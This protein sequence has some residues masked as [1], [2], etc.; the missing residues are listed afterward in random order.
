MDNET[1]TA[2]L[3]RTLIEQSKDAASAARAASVA[4]TRGADRVLLLEQRIES[5]RAA[6]IAEHNK[7]RAEFRAELTALETEIEAVR[8]RVDGSK[9][10]PAGTPPVAVEAAAAS[11]RATGATHEMAALEGRVIAALAGAEAR[12]AADRAALQKQLAAQDR[13]LGV[14]GRGLRR[15][16]S[17]PTLRT[18]PAIIAAI[19]ALAAATRGATSPSSSLPP[20]VVGSPHALAR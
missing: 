9:P 3:L 11:V 7:T 16:L 2:E 18:L 14:G 13:A 20:A 1:T 17:P 15:V 4:A 19:A 8:A 5:N 6:S 12:A 10:P